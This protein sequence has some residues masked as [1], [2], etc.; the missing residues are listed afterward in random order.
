MSWKDIL[1]R[2]QQSLPEAGQQAPYVPEPGDETFGRNP[3]KPIFNPG[4]RMEYDPKRPIPQTGGTQKG[5]P[6]ERRPTAWAPTAIGL[7]K[8]AIEGL[9]TQ[10]GDPR[11]TANEMFTPGLA[12]LPV[13]KIEWDVILEEEE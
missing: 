10:L 5:D 13:H 6:Y 8:Q 4:V 7:N 2:E 1:N 3:M 9:R 11:Q 12:G